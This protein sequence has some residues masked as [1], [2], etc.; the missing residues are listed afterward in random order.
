MRLVGSAA[1]SAMQRTECQ[2]VGEARAGTRRR[3][4]DADAT[5]ARILKAAKR[6]FALHGLGG[7]RVDA[8]SER[9]KANK[10]MLYHYFGGKEALFTAVLEDAY[11]DIRTAERELNLEDME[12]EAAMDRLVEFTW[13]YY[14]RHP[15]FLTLVNS[16]N[17]HKARHIR[18]SDTIREVFPPFVRMVQSIIDRGVA[19]GVF[20]KGV[21]PIQLNITI[22]AIG[23]YYLTNRYIGSVIY[24]RD[25][26][27][28]EQLERR[29][30][31]N[32]E[33]IRSILRK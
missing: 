7:A 8:I 11:V 29:L 30:A 26:M 20:R 27:S 5:K 13:R 1:E 22:A 17:L 28:D 32:L 31:F 23:Y 19:K 6:E 15:E 10:R 12:P 25:F 18:T 9:A 24:D 4:R 33:T 3:V 2:T 14:L 21:D 16:E